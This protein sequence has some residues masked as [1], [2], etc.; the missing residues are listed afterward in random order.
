MYDIKQF[1]LSSGEE[2]LAEI[3]EW[4][5]DESSDLVIR[6]AVSLL[7]Y[8]D[9]NG[10]KFYGFKTWI[11]FTEDPDTLSVMSPDHIIST[12]NPHALLVSQYKN[13]LSEI[14]ESSM[15][16]NRHLMEEEMDK[17]A[18]LTKKLKDFLLNETGENVDFDDS[19]GY[20]FGTSN[21]IKFPP[22]H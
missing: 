7:R 14:V 17:M 19:D 13:A 10:S 2:I 11:H 8:E 5:G 15:E 3:I 21:V 1:K 6:N 9:T 16:R 12:T 4:P 20:D 22:I 18:L